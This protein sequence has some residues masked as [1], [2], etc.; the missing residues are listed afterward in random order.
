MLHCSHPCPSVQHA[1]SVS[2]GRSA[3]ALRCDLAGLSLLQHLSAVCTGA[4]FRGRAQTG[5]LPQAALLPTQNGPGLYSEMEG[6][7]LG[8]ATVTNNMVPRKHWFGDL[9]VKSNLDS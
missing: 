1:A 6:Q 5:S 9:Q 8:S 7:C 3:R 4:Q 2:E